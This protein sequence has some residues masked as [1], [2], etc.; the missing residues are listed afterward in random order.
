MVTVD[1]IPALRARVAEARTAGA[2]VAF[3]PTMGALHDGHISLVERARAEA[4]FVVAS[5]FVN[6]LQFGPGEDLSR[7]PRD[8][9]GD[10]ARLREAG[11]DLLFAPSGE[12]MYPGGPDIRVDPGVLATRWEGEIRPGHFAGVLTVVAKL[13]N[14][15]QPDISVFGRKDFQQASLVRAMVNALNFPVRVVVAPTIRDRDGLA[16]SSRNAYLGAEDRVRAR[17]IPR[18]LGTMVQLWAGGEHGSGALE[19]AGREVISSA[20]LEVDYLAIVS[21]RTLEPAG[22]AEAGCVIIV[23]ARSGSTRLID[24]TVLGEPEPLPGT[25]SQ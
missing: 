2:R 23:A 17:A 24:N 22:K 21:P 19:R 3:V 7:Y 13:F 4:P 11:T 12:T 5:V 15:I 10:A 1:D 16:M 20:G 25:G 9:P 18:A 6:S 14:I 8:L